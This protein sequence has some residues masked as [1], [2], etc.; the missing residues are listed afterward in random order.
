M[1]LFKMVIQLDSV[2]KAFNGTDFLN[3]S[4]FIF[5]IFLVYFLRK[6]ESESKRERETEKVNRGGAERVGKRES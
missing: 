5:L 4:I 3:S 1:V 2:K 6:S